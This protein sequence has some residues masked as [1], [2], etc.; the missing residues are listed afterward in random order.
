MSASFTLHWCANSQPAASSAAG[1]HYGV[2]GPLG[3]KYP[4]GFAGTYQSGYSS[5]DPD[6][7]M[8]TICARPQKPVFR[9]ALSLRLMLVVAAI[10]GVNS[11]PS[12]SR[13]D[14]IVNDPTGNAIYAQPVVQFRYGAPGSIMVPC[15]NGSTSPI[16]NFNPGVSVPCINGADFG[17]ST[18]TSPHSCGGFAAHLIS[19]LCACLP[20]RR[21]SG[22]QNFTGYQYPGLITRHPTGNEDYSVAGAWQVCAER[23]CRQS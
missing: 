15:I 6:R 4:K 22:F 21:R 16:I 18:H 2:N 14:E 20:P 8:T 3:R 13:A 5:G 19:R 10:C 17:G 12:Q 1:Y 11:N 7:E 23:G 9:C